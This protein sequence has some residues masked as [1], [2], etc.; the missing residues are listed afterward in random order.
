MFGWQTAE[1]GENG[2]A[3]SGHETIQAQRD[4]A[5]HAL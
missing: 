3:R 5:L 4:G 2:K 1:Y